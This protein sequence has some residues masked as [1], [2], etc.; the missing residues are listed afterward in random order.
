MTATS[1]Q[2]ILESLERF[3]RLS[4]WG[5]MLSVLLIGQGEWYSSRSKLTW[6]MRGSKFN[7]LYFQLVVKEQFTR[8]TEF[9]FVPTPRKTEIINGKSLLDQRKNAPGLTSY[10]N[11]MEGLPLQTRNLLNP[12]Y[13]EY[14]MGFPIGWTDLQDLETQYIQP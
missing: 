3:S 14:L 12:E 11:Q 2:K 10:V 13:V 5:K 9:G 4:L 8:G 7:R 1:G 6:K